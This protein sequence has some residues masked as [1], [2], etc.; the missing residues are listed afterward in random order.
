EPDP[1]HREQIKSALR[2]IRRE[3]WKAAFIQ[4]VVDAVA[5]FLAANLLVLVTDPSWLPE[6]IAL[7]A[8][9]TAQLAELLG[10][11][12]SLAV[13]GSALLAAAVAVLALVAGIG[14][15]VRR[16]LVERFEAVNPPVA[17]ALRTARDTVE[18]GASSQ[19]A[20]RLYADVLDHLQETSSI[21]LVNLRRIALTLVIIAVMSAAT[22][23]VAVYEITIDGGAGDDAVDTT[24]NE[25]VEF[26]GL[27][28]GNA[29]LGDSEE[30]SAGDENISAQVES[31]G[32]DQELDDQDRFPAT[33]GPSGGETGSVD[34][35][36]AGFAQPEQIE[37][38]EL[39]REYNI[40]IRETEE[41]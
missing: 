10:H 26:T 29:V 24:A 20:T 4:S 27:R 32:G 9:A 30:V 12:G 28:D 35:Q 23:Q 38:A 8:D 16:P 25:S 36:Q 37:D 40:R 22:T 3:G 2:Q 31:T 41:N 17:E 6:P 34:S 15:R 5:L 11:S 14:L 33:G 13:P 39:I 18:D 19:M 7:P 1:D 21:G